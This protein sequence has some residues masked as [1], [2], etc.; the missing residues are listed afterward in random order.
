M[1]SALHSLTAASVTLVGTHFALS[2]PLRAPLHKALGAGGFQLLYNAVAVAA[3][4][5][6]WLAFGDSTTGDL[7]GAGIVGNIA[8]SL[9]SLAALVLFVGSITPQNPSM[10]MPGAEEAARA[11]PQGVFRVTRHPMMWGFALWAASHLVLLYSWRTTIVAT[12]VLVLALLGATLQ[13]RRKAREMGEAWEV[14]A[15]NTTYLPRLSG[16][17]AITPHTWIIAI[18]AWTVITWLHGPLGQGAVG[19]WPALGTG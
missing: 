3:I 9:L 2:H 15:S 7:P 17:P 18:V 11:E 16:I 12:A 1:D 14:F 19:I 4:V 10:P 5:W 13:D 6:M 8:A